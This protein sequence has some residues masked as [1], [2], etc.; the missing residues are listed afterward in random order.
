MLSQFKLTHTIC[1][2]PETEHIYHTNNDTHNLRF[3]KLVKS[4]V[5]K[6]VKPISQ[7]I[8]NELYI[9]TITKGGCPFLAGATVII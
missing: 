1:T 8:K 2:Q 5:V 9:F 7:I 4:Q 6:N 3:D